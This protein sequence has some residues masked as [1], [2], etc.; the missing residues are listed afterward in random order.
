MFPLY[1]FIQIKISIYCWH[2]TLAS[3]SCVEHKKTKPNDN[4]LLQPIVT[5][6]SFEMIGIDI[7]RAAARKQRLQVHTSHDRLVHGVG[8]GVAPPVN[9]E[10][11]NR[12]T[13]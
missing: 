5:T 7:K 1:S 3:S 11:S 13:L 8:R 9:R 2:L 4:G 10:G 6:H 12:E